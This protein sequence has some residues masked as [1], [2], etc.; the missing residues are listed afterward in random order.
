MFSLTVVCFLFLLI[1]RNIAK[2]LTYQVGSLPSKYL[3]VALVENTMRNIL[4]ED[5]WMKR[6]FSSWTFRALN[7]VGRHTLIKYTLLNIHCCYICFLP[8]PPRTMSLKPPAISKEY[9][10]GEVAT[11]RGN[12]LW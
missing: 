7:I 1:Q 3:G 11:R 10:H 4:W 6:K 8:S 9:S 5:C 12:G 2:I